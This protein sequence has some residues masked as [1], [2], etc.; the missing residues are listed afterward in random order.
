MWARKEFIKERCPG[1]LVV[2]I[3][4][5]WARKEFIKERCPGV[6]VVKIG[7][8]WARKSYTAPLG[9]TRAVVLR[10]DQ[11]GLESLCCR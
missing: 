4:P 6:L 8:M 3:G 10:S 2:K 7:P 5:M 1:V 9:K 11:C